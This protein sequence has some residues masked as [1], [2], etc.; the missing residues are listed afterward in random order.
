MFCVLHLQS[1]LLPLCHFT[2]QKLAWCEITRPWSNSQYMVKM[3]FKATSAF[4][5]LSDAF[6]FS[7]SGGTIYVPGPI[8]GDSD[9]EIK[10]QQ[11]QHRKGLQHQ[12]FLKAAAV[13]WNCNCHTETWQ[14]LYKV[15]WVLKIQPSAPK[16]ETLSHI[17]FLTIVLSFSSIWIFYKSHVS[18]CDPWQKV[19]SGLLYKTLP[20]TCSVWTEACQ[21]KSAGSSLML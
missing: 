3:A 19:C 2:D 10:K 13:Y 1:P 17:S 8:I 4:P 12:S 6:P 14:V 7:M 20:Q 21:L 5:T 18:L 9:R 15:L 11:I 16:Q